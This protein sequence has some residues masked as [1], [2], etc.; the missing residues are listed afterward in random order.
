MDML[1]RLDQPPEKHSERLSQFLQ[2]MERRFSRAVTPSDRVMRL[3]G[4]GF[5]TSELLDRALTWI[6]HFNLEH[7]HGPQTVTYGEEEL[8]VLCTVRNGQPYIRNFIDHYF[9]LGA[10]HIIFL[11]NSSSDQ[12]VSIAQ[13]YEDVT[14]LRTTLPFKKYKYVMRRY[15]IERFSRARWSLLVDIDELFDY[16]YSEIVSLRSF[17]EY[18]NSRPY[19]SVVAQ[20]LDMFPDGPLSEQGGEK[21]RTSTESA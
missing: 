15:L 4:A 7:V 5:Y 19:T 20:M 3:T 6:L 2:I 11:D 12:T 16:P 17:L 13:Q 14:V 9:S 21:R 8:I 18:L 1:N 10:S